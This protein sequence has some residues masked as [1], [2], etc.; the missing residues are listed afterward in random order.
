MKK[1]KNNKMNENNNKNKNK[2]KKRKTITRERERERE[3]ERLNSWFRFEFGKTVL[4]ENKLE[5]PFSLERRFL[6]SSLPPMTRSL[7]CRPTGA[8]R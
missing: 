6:A 2:N 3:R 5:L 8:S 1:N 4:R 7:S